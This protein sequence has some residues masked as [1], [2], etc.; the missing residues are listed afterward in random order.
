MNGKKTHCG[1]MD[2]GGCTLIVET[3]GGRVKRITPDPAGPLSAGHMCP[4][5]GALPE[6]LN[7]PQR[8]RRPLQ[9]VGERG[10]G[11][12]REISWEEAIEAAAAGLDRIREAHGAR[13][14]AFC[15][16]APKGLE[17]FVLIRLANTFG[18]PNVVGP[19]NIC[20]MPREM[21]G[22]HTCGFFPIADYENPTEAVLVWGSNITAT[23]E[24]GVICTRMLNRVRRDASRLIVVDPRRTETARRADIW[25]PIRPGT[26][27]CLALGFLHVI[28]GEDL[29]DRDFV[30]NHTHGFEALSEWVRDFDPQRV[31]E[32]TELDKERIIEAARMFGRARPGTMQWGNGIEQNRYN[33]D[34]ARALIALMG[35]GGNLDAPGGNIAA[36]PPPVMRLGEFVR[37][38]LQPDRGRRMLS[39][40]Y[41]PAPGFMIVPPEYLKRAVVEGEPYPVHG[42]YVHVSNPV[43][44][45]S[46]CNDTYEALGKLDF[47]VVTETFMSP[48]AAMADL[49]L[50][51]ATEL[52]FNDLGHFG[53]AHGYVLARPQVVEPPAECRPNAWIINELGKVLGPAEL[54]WD[55]YE[56]MLDDILAPSGLKY[57]DLAELGILR[58]KTRYYKYRES[59]FKTP[60]GKLELALS[61]A[62]RFK[63]NSLPAWDGPP[64]ETGSDYPLVLTAH[65][66]RNFFCSDHRY[67]RS[68]LDREP[69]PLVEVHPDTAAE[70]GVE[71]GADVFVETKKGRIR[72]K[73]RVTDGIRPG[74]LSVVHGW[75]K[76]DAGAEK[77]ESWAETSLNVLTD[78]R[79]R[80]RAMGAPDLRGIPAA[81]SPAGAT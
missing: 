8:L 12:W 15:Q 58:G 7:H 55:H 18:S 33:F 20:H 4:K 23:N 54:W 49:V 22:I 30:E 6:L 45:W 17:H 36:T 29:F 68:L 39:A 62:E 44:A 61:K 56:D 47:L 69:E 50:P 38:D 42:A 81:L 41:G 31:A 70:A 26:D 71:D 28:I 52:E 13:S 21:A 78:S 77:K 63:I 43:V 72:L 51:A 3:E 64:E 79:V 40:E 67:I 27:L 74:T 16:G 9:R 59:G 35:L 75:W 57:S 60:T 32:I 73:A 37:G 80:G 48:T 66:S 1:R 24:E 76:P 19:Q 46:D 10:S 2:H 25:L 53:L 11:R 5:A 14:V 34:T 65:K